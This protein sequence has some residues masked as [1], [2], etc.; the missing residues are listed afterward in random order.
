VTITLTPSRRTFRGRPGANEMLKLT[1]WTS[2]NIGRVRLKGYFDV[3]CGMGSVHRRPINL[4]EFS[5]RFVGSDPDDVIDVL[6]SEWLDWDYT[7]CDCDN[8]EVQ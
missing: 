6:S 1:T 4:V 2:R 7:G 5:D 8:M 3:Y